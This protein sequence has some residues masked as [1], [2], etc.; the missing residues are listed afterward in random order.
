VRR[1]QRGS[2]RP[3]LRLWTL[4]SSRFRPEEH[5]SAAR[6]A[7]NP[8]EM[9]SQAYSLA[10]QSAPRFPDGPHGCANPLRGPC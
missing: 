1:P 5:Q 2:W 8:L 4:S 3:F 10:S 7:R 6:M 9:G